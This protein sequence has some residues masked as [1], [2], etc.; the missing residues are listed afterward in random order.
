M[1][2]L[3]LTY[4]EEYKSKQLRIHQTIILK[5]L[6]YALVFIL[7]LCFEIFSYIINFIR[8]FIRLFNL[9]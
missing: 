4:C 3:E 8:L 2:P 1:T 5:I 9:K 6:Q 7:L